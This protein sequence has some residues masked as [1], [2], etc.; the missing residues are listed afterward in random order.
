MDCHLGADGHEFGRII[1]VAAM[2]GGAT[3]AAA[4]TH[5]LQF[6]KKSCYDSNRNRPN[7]F[8]FS[9][10]LGNERPNGKTKEVE[11]VENE[12]IGSRSFR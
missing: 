6:G 10:C 7:C 3:R 12:A 11:T 5:R 8:A 2:V 4:T 1:S 9:F